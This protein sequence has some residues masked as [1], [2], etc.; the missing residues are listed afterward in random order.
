MA[1]RLFGLPVGNVGDM[2]IS[3]RGVKV[4]LSINSEYIQRLSKGSYARLVREGYVGAATIQIVPSREP[5]GAGQPLADGDQIAHIP[6]RG[7]PQ[8]VDH[9]KNPLTPM[10]SHTLP[11]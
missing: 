10:I 4:Q 8:L 6:V 11:L 7:M 3:D 2:D 9:F 5:G 1:V